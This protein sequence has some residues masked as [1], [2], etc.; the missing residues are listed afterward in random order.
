[1]MTQE[2]H[3]ILFQESLSVER[4]QGN[5]NGANKKPT[6]IAIGGIHGN[7]YAGVAAIQRVFKALENNRITCHGNFYG[8]LGNIPALQMKVRFIDQDLNRVWTSNQ[9]LKSIKSPKTIEQK[10][11]V[12]LYKTIKSILSSNEGPFYFLDLHT[13]SCATNPFI[14]ISDSLNN[15]QFSSHFKIPIVLGIEEFLEGPLLTYIN[16]FGHVALGFEAGQH[17]DPKSADYAESF[18]WSALL[19]S[20]CIAADELNS[21]IPVETTLSCNSKNKCFYEIDFKYSIDKN[22]EFKIVGQFN[23]FEKIKKGQQ[24]ATSNGLPVCAQ[25]NGRIFMPLYQKKG[26][27]GYFIVNRISSFWLA[28][29]T[30]VRSFKMH[31]LLQLLPGVRA[32]KEFPYTLVVNPRTAKFLATEIFHLFGYRRKIFRKDKWYFI[33]RDREVSRFI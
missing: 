30:S 27:D 18:L 22:E 7:E 3:S 19:A 20:G 2:V 28:L 10:Q 5:V 31:L 8:I 16:E 1:M 15:R 32:S 14:T 12:E 23:N 29:S 6:V 13:T 33:R 24:I 9:L 21:Q 26:D 11:Q 17:D 25:Q 4:I